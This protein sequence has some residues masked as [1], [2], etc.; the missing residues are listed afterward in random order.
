MEENT[1]LVY[2]GKI[3]E[4]EKIVDANFVVSA[5][6]ICGKGGKWKGVIRKADFEINQLCVV[7]L[8]DSLIPP[9]ED[10]KFMESINWRVRMRRFRGS[11]SEVLI[12][13]CTHKDPVFGMDC[14]ALMGVTKYY[15]PIPVNLDGVVIGELPSFIPM[16]DEPNY[17]NSQGQ[18][19]I[20]KLKGQPY[21]VTE[22]ADGSSTTAYKYKGKFGVCNRRW[23][24]EKDEN[25]GY[26]KV[27]I[28]YHLEEK[29]PDGYAV[30]WETCGPNIQKN[31]MNLKDVDG[32]IFSGYKIDE[33]RYLGWE[34][35][36]VL[37]VKLRMNA[38]RHIE[39]GPCFDPSYIHLLGEGT[40]A[41]GKN[42]EGVVVRSKTNLLGDKPVSFK[43]MNLDYE[44]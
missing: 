20:E 40:Y 9:S 26:W 16:T 39:D 11:P 8:P 18:E 15:K 21:Y 13:P 1:G 44:I 24:L 27:A 36:S 34:E 14:T 7:Y 3:I 37:C 30:Q 19:G 25:I 10:M 23:E 43:V 32:F 2:I 4:L 33:K 17:Q 41:S 6:V 42:R 12:M 28:K 35:L 31:P 38:C 22:K 29:L 5:T